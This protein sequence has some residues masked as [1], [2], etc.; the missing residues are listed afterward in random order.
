ML[1]DKSNV[2]CIL[3]AKRNTVVTETDGSKTQIV[4]IRSDN[5]DSLNTRL[6]K[7]IFY[8]VHC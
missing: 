8:T 2:S 6:L 3:Y 5:R 7:G 1:K 4:S